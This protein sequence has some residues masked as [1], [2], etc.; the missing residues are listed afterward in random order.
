MV[1]VVHWFL[2]IIVLYHLLHTGLV[3][4]LSVTDAFIF[5]LLKDILWGGVVIVSLGILLGTGNR[6][7]LK[8]RL[9][10]FFMLMAG[11]A[12]CFVVRTP[13]WS[14]RMS[15]LVGMKY[16]IFPLFVLVT[17]WAAGAGYVVTLPRTSAVFSSF[18]FTL[19]VTALVG[20]VIRQLSKVLFPDLFFSFGYGPVGDY[21]LGANPPLYYRT[22][23]G[24]LMRFSWI[25]A[26]P[27]NMGY[28]LVAFFSRTV[29]YC[30]QVLTTTRKKRGI[31]SLYAI[32]TIRTF[33]R[34]AW[35]GIG[36]QLLLLARRRFPQRKRFVP[37]VFGIGLL[38]MVWLSV[39]K[40]WST[41]GHIV[42]WQEWVQ[43]IIAN[44]RWYGPWSSWPAVH[45]T[46]VYLPE[47][48]YLQ[49]VLDLGIL[50]FMRRLSIFL[51]IGRKLIISVRTG[52][53][54]ESM[55]LSMLLLWCVGLAVEGL[56]LHTLEDSMVN[57]LLF[58]AVM[59]YGAG[60]K[61]VISNNIQSFDQVSN[62]N[63]N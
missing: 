26:G 25:F 30:T 6:T 2:L 11:I 21:V 3:Y 52:K 16:D 12:L 45:Y 46:G 51:V 23:P 35:I 18:L 49:I 20:G 17:A 55:F 60:E 39:Y 36:V 61:W 53:G 29:R 33:S 59:V 15:F 27:N 48:Q 1:R 58:T 57:Y 19:L 63:G 8:R 5:S 34:G 7:V 32:L 28:F 37:R 38:G 42:A 62:I 41:T 14:T 47:N 40:A 43:A 44:P 13:S 4:G 24:G 9:F 54:Q 22:G 56:F 10:P 50:W 31:L